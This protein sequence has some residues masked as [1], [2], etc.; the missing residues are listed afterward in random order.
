MPDAVPGRLRRAPVLER[1]GARG[2]VLVDNYDSFTLNL[3]HLLAQLGADVQVVRH[4]EV[5][6]ADVLAARPRGVVLSPGPLSPTEAGICVPLVRACAG[7][8]EPVP[9]LG[10]CLG[11]QA[12]GAAFGARVVRARVPVHGRALPVRHDGHGVLA[13][14]PDPF[15]AARYHSLVVSPHALPTVLEAHAWSP[16][17]E[18][19][20]LAHRTLPVV[21]VQFHPESYLTPHGT[22]LLSAFLAS[23]GLPARRARVVR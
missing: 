11:H 8:D 22:R 19:M 10:V 5:S 2:V 4:D 21:G 12:I 3:A 18:I 9:L 20:A 14:L 7:A 13:G 23:C 17:G 15:P 6:V 1:A 16:E